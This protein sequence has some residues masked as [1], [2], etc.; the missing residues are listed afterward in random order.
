MMVWTPCDESLPPFPKKSLW[1]NEKGNLTIPKSWKPLTLDDGPWQ[2]GYIVC[3][4]SGKVFYSTWYASNKS[5]TPHWTTKAE[6]TAWMP[7][8]KPYKAEREEECSM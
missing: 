2:E 5:N 7:M 6:I 1:V 3:S 8:P 4:K